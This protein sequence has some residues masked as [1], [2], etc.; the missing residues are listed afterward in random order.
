MNDEAHNEPEY[1]DLQ[2]EDIGFNPAD[3]ATLSFFQRE[4]KI[5]ITKDDYGVIQELARKNDSYDSFY[6]QFKALIQ[7][8]YDTKAFE[9]TGRQKRNFDK[10]LKQTWHKSAS[11]VL[12]GM[13]KEVL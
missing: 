3:R 1:Q 8:K 9:F 13:D 7:A 5:R 2:E 10:W 11:K 4:M 6:E 12:I